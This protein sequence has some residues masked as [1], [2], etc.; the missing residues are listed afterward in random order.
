MRRA[1]ITAAAAVFTLAATVTA[2]RATEPR[3]TA[4]GLMLPGTFTGDLP[5]AS[6]PGIRHQLDLWPDQVFQLRRAW[7]G[8][9][10]TRDLL[11][12][13]HVDPSR[14]ALVLD[15]GETPP[16]QFEILGNGHLRLLDQQGRKIE[17]TLP[18][19][20]VRADAFTPFEPKL[21]LRGMF[22]YFADS[23]RFTECRSGRS[24]PVAMEADFIALQ[25]A[26]MDARSAPQA[27]VLA[28]I[29]ARIAARQKMEGEGTQPT[30]VVDRFVALHPGETCAR[31]QAAPSLRNT[32]WRI[33]RLR[34]VEIAADQGRR[35]PY[36]LLLADQPRF[37]GTVG[38]NQMIGGVE[39]TGDALRFGQVAGTMMMCPPPLDQQERLFA[40]V[41]GE[42]VSWRIDGQRLQLR[43]GSGAVVAAFKAAYLP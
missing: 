17:S 21:E 30:V 9:D 1:L 26:Y 31:A 24:W 35:E 43:N 23:A 40:Q 6:G 33:E 20:L 15:G 18:Y 39:V 29:E 13:W 38:C 16:T 41:L 7:I 28:A 22:L 5:A 14:R 32:V 2:V 36:L 4:P 27:P 10:T 11:G 37:A 42:V 25:R 8:T 3:L 34:D 19:E 12:R